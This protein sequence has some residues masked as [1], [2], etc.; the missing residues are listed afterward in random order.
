MAKLIEKYT[1]A[2]VLPKTKGHFITKRAVLWEEI[3][4]LNI[5][6]PTDRA[7]NEVHENGQ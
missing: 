7:S 6:L 4:L 3:I 1:V 5:Y 2:G